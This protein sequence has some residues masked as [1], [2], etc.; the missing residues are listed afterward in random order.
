MAFTNSAIP[1]AKED[2]A[3]KYKMAS[4]IKLFL[5]IKTTPN[6]INNDATAKEEVKYPILSSSKLATNTNIPKVK[7]NA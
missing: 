5:I 4:P 7:V 6:A 3:T 2:T 1:K